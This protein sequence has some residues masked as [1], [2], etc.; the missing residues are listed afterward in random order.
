MGR[1]P[2]KDKE[3]RELT[4]RSLIE[5][6]RTVIL[7]NGFDGTQVRDIV[8][9]AGVAIGTFYSYFKNL[10]EFFVRATEEAVEGI[11]KEIRQARGIQDGTAFS[12]PM[13][14]V[15][16]SFR[17]FFDYVA[18]NRAMA[19]FLLRQ[20]LSMSPYGNLIRKVFEEIVE[21]LQEDLEIAAKTGLIKPLPT[22]LTA[23]MIIGMALHMGEFFASN[24]DNHL[25][26][27]TML[28]VISKVTWSGISRNHTG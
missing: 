25:D 22:R 23:E 6:G 13:E 5:A 20:R 28:D 17:T 24:P 11:R 7:R 8:R 9:E 15:R 19:L 12:D 3:K 27:E 14:A 10:D 1:N 4:K 26:R 18:S 2:E 21:D 16:A